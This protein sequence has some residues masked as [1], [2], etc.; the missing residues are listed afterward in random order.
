L[1]LS[2]RQP[3]RDGEPFSLGS[4]R[5]AAVG[6]PCGSTCENIWALAICYSKQP[7]LLGANDGQHGIFSGLD[8]LALRAVVLPICTLRTS[9]R[10]TLSAL[11]VAMATETAALFALPPAIVFG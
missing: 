11:S 4:Y 2:P 5:G 6:I 3:N 8:A 7:A 1:A 9:A 10:D